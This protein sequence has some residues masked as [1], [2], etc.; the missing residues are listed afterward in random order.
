MKKNHLFRF[1]AVY[2]LSLVRSLLFASTRSFG[3]PAEITGAFGL[4]FGAV[5]D[6]SILKEK[7]RMG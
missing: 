6:P 2:V 3:E 1:I 7:R 5:A 4:R